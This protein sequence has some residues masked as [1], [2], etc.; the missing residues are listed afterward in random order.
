MKSK[1]IIAANILTALFCI[2]GYAQESKYISVEDA[3]AAAM[4]NNSNVKMAELD[5]KTANANYRQTDA[6]FLPQVDLDYT[7]L[8]TNNPLNAFGF[9]LQHQSVTAS[10]FDPAKLNYPGSS[11]DYSA[12]AEVKLP[13]LNMDMMYARKGAKVQ[14]EVY[15]YKAERTRQYIEFETKKAYSQ[16][17]LSYLAKGILKKTLADVKQIHQSVTNFYNQGLVQKSDVLN[18]QVQVNTIETALAK[19]ESNIKNASDGL[20]ILMGLEITGDTYQV[21]T[22]TQKE[23]L[24]SADIIAPTRADLMALSKVVDAST[25]MIKS[26]KMAFVPRINAFGA[27]QFND[28]KPLKFGS[29]SYLIGINMNWKIFSGNQNKNKVRSYQF[30]RDKMT[31]ELNQQKSQSQAELEKTKR[32]LNDSQIEI[33]KQRTNVEQAEEAL[34]IT[35]NRF[36]EGLVNTTDLLMAQAQ[37]SKQELQLAQAIMAYNITQSFMEFITKSE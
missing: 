18:A 8:S 28:G 30:Q 34:R 22:L 9:L 35:S 36:K 5:I 29:D 15:K 19:A 25:L 24:P 16:L 21:D 11:Q 32:D 37:L 31:E 10:D 14:E 4:K 2:S 17:Q 20:R 12:K 26:S 3:I 27:Y 33:L 13:I 6:T 23:L 1:K 7:A